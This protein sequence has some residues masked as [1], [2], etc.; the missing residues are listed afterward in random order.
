MASLG[1]R[2]FGDMAGKLEGRKPLK[3]FRRDPLA[4]IATLIILAVVVGAIF[5]PIIAPYPEQGDGVPDISN[6]FQPPSR[7]HLMGTD[8]LGRDVLS[9]IL[10]GAKIS[11]TMGVLI[12]T[13][14]LIIGLPLG[15][16]AG[17]F[18]GWTDELIM[19]IT[20]MFLAFP[21]LLLAIAVSLSLGRSF[22]SNLIA[23]SI[24]WWPWYTRMAR[25]LAKSIRERKYI[26]AAMSMGISDWVIIIRH[27]IP[28]IAT[29]V[30]VEATT[31]IGLAI[32]TAA[33]LSFIGLGLPPPEAD[34]GEMV[35]AGR[36]YIFEQWWFAAFPGLAILLTALAFNLLGD[37]VH[38]SANPHQRGKGE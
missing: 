14:G 12:V 33:G 7:E 37:S 11:I 29:P 2:W 15:A 3:V 13:I 16:I 28:N 10:Y 9:R 4:A 27:V 17:Y 25:P 20:D 32:L 31:E 22:T 34:W 5:A 8:N 26:D 35:S 6:K 24:T 21:P 23:I 30:L 1:Q 38:E 19:R 18:G 36:L